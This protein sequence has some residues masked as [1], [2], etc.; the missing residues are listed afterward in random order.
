MVKGELEEVKKQLEAKSWL[1]KVKVKQTN[2][3][4]LIMT[5]HQQH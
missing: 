5:I 3:V 2:Y 1:F 4:F